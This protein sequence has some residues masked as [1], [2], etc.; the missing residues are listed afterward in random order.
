M[1][2]RY[3]SLTVRC[4]P[5]SP[6]VL[7]PCLLTHQGGLGRLYIPVRTSFKIFSEVF[8]FIFLCIF[9]SFSSISLVFFFFFLVFLFLSLQVCTTTSFHISVHQNI[10]ISIFICNNLYF[11]CLKHQ[12]EVPCILASKNI[13]VQY[14]FMG[15]TYSTSI[16]FYMEHTTL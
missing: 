6:L 11:L 13:Y 9:C 15:H 16:C 3:I 1:C 5:V 12:V 8:V 14:F 10:I 7:G 2:G 4:I